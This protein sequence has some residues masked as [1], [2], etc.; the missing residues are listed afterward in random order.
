MRK[1]L[2]ILLAALVLFSLNILPVRSSRPMP[3]VTIEIHEDFSATMRAEVFRLIHEPETMYFSNVLKAPILNWISYRGNVTMNLTQAGPRGTY[4]MLAL[5][6]PGDPTRRASFFPKAAA[7]GYFDNTT[8]HTLMSFFYGDR[9]LLLYGVRWN[10]INVTYEA[11]PF[12]NYTGVAAIAAV[13]ARNDKIKRLEMS[14][15][16]E[17]QMGTG[18]LIVNYNITVETLPLELRRSPSGYYYI[19]L[20]PLTVALPDDITANLWVNFTSDKIEILGGNPAP[21]VILWNNALWE[22]VPQLQE[23]GKSLVII[24]QRVEPH[25]APQVVLLAVVPPIIVGAYLFWRFRSEEG[26]KKTKSESEQK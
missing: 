6:R 13:S 5:P 25:V 21:K 19:D 1:L 18:A 14:Y 23:N 4:S 16:T 7:A 26:R 10:F 8:V 20:T 12:V 24:I 15:I 17:T 22:F 9:F 2:A 3:K 11:T